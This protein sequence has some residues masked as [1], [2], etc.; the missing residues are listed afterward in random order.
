MEPMETA[1]KTAPQDTNIE[2]DTESTELSD[3]DLEDIAGGTEGGSGDGGD[4]S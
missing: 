3:T 2:L 1:K 4:K